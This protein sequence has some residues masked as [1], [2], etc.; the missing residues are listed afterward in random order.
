MN[1]GHRDV[2]LKKVSYREDETTLAFAFEGPGIEVGFD[3]AVT[4]PASETQEYSVLRGPLTVK[5]GS[6]TETRVVYV[7]NGC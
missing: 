1:L 3:G 6:R 4:V 7:H 2:E 5:A